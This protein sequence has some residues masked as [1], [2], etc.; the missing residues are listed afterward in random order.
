[1]APPPPPSSTLLFV[2]VVSDM[3]GRARLNSLVDLN[4]VSA[5]KIAP[6]LAEKDDEDASAVL[7]LQVF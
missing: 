3:S 4:M 5:I 6:P 1:M 7:R 2:K